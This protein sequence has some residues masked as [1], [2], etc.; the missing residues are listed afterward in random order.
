MAG[1][2]A[3]LSFITGDFRETELTDDVSNVSPLQLVALYEWLSFYQRQYQH[4]SL[5][6]GIIQK[7]GSLQSYYCKLRLPWQKAADSK[8]NLKL[9][10]PSFHYVIQNGVVQQDESGALQKV[11]EWS[12]N[13]LVS[14]GSCIL[15]GPALPDV[16][17]L[18]T[19]LNMILM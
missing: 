8:Q 11:V 5:L 18:N 10:R 15:L 13:G 12:E 17:A 4:D 3:S 7:V 16:S 6:G 1:K 9:K 2:D 19:H 14:L